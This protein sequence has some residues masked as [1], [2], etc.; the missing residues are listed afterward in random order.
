MDIKV[1]YALRDQQWLTSLSV[2]ELTTLEDAIQLSHILDHV[3]QHEKA[4]LVFGINGKV[5]PHHT[6]LN[7]GDRVEI[8]RPR[9]VNPKEQR[10]QRA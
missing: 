6:K 10:R 3:P 9:L 5:R 7:Q 1:V 2:P 8:Y 4:Q